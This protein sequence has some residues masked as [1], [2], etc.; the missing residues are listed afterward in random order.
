MISTI[1]GGRGYLL[2]A[3]SIGSVAAS[4]RSRW[5]SSSDALSTRPVAS[6][7]TSS[8]SRSAHSSSTQ[9]ASTTQ[10]R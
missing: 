8:G 10:S 6:R 9:S 2:P 4:I 7:L 1:S 5:Q 3:A